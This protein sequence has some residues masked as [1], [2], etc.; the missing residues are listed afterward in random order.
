M[1]STRPSNVGFIHRLEQF[2]AL[3]PEHLVA[4][5]TA[6][7]RNVWTGCSPPRKNFSVTAKRSL[8]S[9]VLPSGT[10]LMRLWRSPSSTNQP[11][12]GSQSGLAC[13]IARCGRNSAYGMAEVVRGG[14]A[15]LITGLL[16]TGA[17]RATYQGAGCRRSSSTSPAGGCC[18]STAP[19]AV[20]RKPRGFWNRP[21]RLQEPRAVRRQLDGCA[22]RDPRRP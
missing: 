7:T 17:A 21:S 14:A 19:R 13:R 12:T 20:G 3:V 9:T 10:T 8:G 1:I 5:R 4:T 6:R 15:T 18:R 22:A 11:M 2:G 16:L